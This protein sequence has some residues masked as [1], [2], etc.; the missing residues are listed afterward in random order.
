MVKRELGLKQLRTAFESEAAGFRYFSGKQKDD[1]S[2]NWKPLAKITPLP[3]HEQCKVEWCI[4]NLTELGISKE[5]V[6]GRFGAAG[7]PAAPPQWS[8]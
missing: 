3:G 5:P 2:A 8:L 4:A 6:A 1:T 7:Q